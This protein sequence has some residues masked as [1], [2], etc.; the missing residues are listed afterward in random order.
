MNESIDTTSYE[1]S[2]D[3]TIRDS[4]K[5]YVSDVMCE[6]VALPLKRCSDDGVKDFIA[7][8]ASSYSTKHI[9]T[10]SNSVAKKAVDA[11][12]RV[13]LKEIAS[14]ILQEKPATDYYEADVS[15]R[16][17][18]EILSKVATRWV[19][20]TTNAYEMKTFCAKSEN[21]T[22]VEVFINTSNSGQSSYLCL[23]GTYLS[24][25][26]PDTLG[27]L[28][29]SL[30]SAYKILSED[31]VP[32]LSNSDCS[33]HIKH[34]LDPELWAVRKKEAISSILES[35][36]GSK[37]MLEII[38]DFFDLSSVDRFYFENNFSNIALEDSYVDDFFKEKITVD[39]KQVYV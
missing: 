34:D 16:K 25:F 8:E 7:K 28:Q 4:L 14:G 31:I 32:V 6:P 23:G 2:D 35:D 30:L 3:V 33:N 21:S 38:L 12:L 9:G 29:K 5:N 20:Q 36:V 27:R 1:I 15:Y 24:G 13:E 26:R 19:F 10:I 18:L 17:I 22:N 11:D 37:S 39:I